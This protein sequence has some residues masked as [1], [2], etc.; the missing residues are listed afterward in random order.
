MFKQHAIDKKMGSKVES[1]QYRH[2]GQYKKNDAMVFMGKWPELIRIV[3]VLPGGQVLQYVK[4][5]QPKEIP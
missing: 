3:W 2:V 5:L 1:H 4:I